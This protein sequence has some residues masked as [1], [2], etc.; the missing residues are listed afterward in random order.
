MIDTSEIT[1]IVAL[2]KKP[3]VHIAYF[4]N[5]HFSHFNISLCCQGC[6]L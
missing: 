5:M 1:G 4:H 2:E 6:L 3:K